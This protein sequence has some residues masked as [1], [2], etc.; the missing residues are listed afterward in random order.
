MTAR[1]NHLG[2]GEHQALDSLSHAHELGERISP[3]RR[4]DHGLG[5][6][7]ALSERMILY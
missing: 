5:G 6:D 3:G 1:D 4:Q 2:S 7:A